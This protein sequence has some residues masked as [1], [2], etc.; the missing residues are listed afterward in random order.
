MRDKDL[1]PWKGWLFIAESGNT[2]LEMEEDECAHVRRK[3]NIVRNR[4]SFTLQ[5]ELVRLLLARK[6]LNSSPNNLQTLDEK[7]Y[8]RTEAQKSIIN[9]LNFFL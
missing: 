8:W 4:P 3:W 9:M 1:Q 7:F 2:W 5:R 6:Q